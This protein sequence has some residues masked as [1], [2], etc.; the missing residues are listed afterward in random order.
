MAEGGRA[1]LCGYRGP[2]P[3]SRWRRLA[4]SAWATDDLDVTLDE[5]RQFFS[6]VDGA[7]MNADVRHHL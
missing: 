6:F 4:T 3:A 5:V 1:G 7:I 2:R